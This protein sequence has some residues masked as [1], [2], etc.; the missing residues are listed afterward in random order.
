[1]PAG[2]DIQGV[3]R[4]EGLDS[5]LHGNDGMGTEVIAVM[6]AEAGTR[7]EYESTHYQSAIRT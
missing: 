5:R 1:M 3:W 6:L 4:T 7:I 2:L